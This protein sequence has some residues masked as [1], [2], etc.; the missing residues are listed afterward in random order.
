MIEL[1]SGRIIHPTAHKSS[2]Y[3]I[4][5]LWYFIFMTKWENLSFPR[6]GARPFTIH[7]SRTEGEEFLSALAGTANREYSWEFVAELEEW[8]YVPAKAVTVKTERF[9]GFGA[10]TANKMGLV[11]AE[12][13]LTPSSESSSYYHI[14]PRAI[15]K[16]MRDSHPT[17]LPIKNQLPSSEDMFHCV[18]MTGSGYESVRIVTELGVTAL[19]YDDAVTRMNGGNIRIP[20]YSADQ[21]SIMRLSDVYGVHDAIREVIADMNDIYDGQIILDYRELT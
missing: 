16:K 10:V 12:A 11:L 20:G 6:S 7:S 13:Q 9:L 1:Q 17:I 18:E 8:R 15:Y 4:P 21:E 19:K 2:I 3:K 14:H 5:F